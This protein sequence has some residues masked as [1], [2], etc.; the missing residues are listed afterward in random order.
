[1]G[2]SLEL[3]FTT[4]AL[5]IV[6]IVASYIYYRRIRM[7]QT[8]YE[9]SRE[10]VAN[11][12]SGF[13]RQV[14][15]VETDLRN[16]E[17]DAAQARYMAEEALKMGRGSN[18]ATLKGLEKVKE[19]NSR[20]EGIEGNMEKVRAEL[21]KLVVQPRAA[22]TP[23]QVDAA[24][25]VQGENVFQKLTDTELGVLQMIM[26]LGEGSV[27]EIRNKIGKTREHTARLLK[28]LYDSGF[29]DRNT[30]GMPYRYSVRKEIRDLLLEKREQAAIS[31]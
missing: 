21:Q 19:L 8:E 2:K 14:K 11:I 27:P 7:A 4:I 22:P 26:D 16:I 18:E 1:M 5:F 9:G 17:G 28:K 12:T 31:L 25:P 20:V 15:K 29:I 10:S 30:S 24:I 23:T 6:T 13:I 3:V